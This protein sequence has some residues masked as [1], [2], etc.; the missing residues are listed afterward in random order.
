M[1]QRSDL[2][3]PPQTLASVIPGPEGSAE[4]VIGPAEARIRWR[5]LEM[6]PMA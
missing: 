5:R 6:T 4:P 1:L 2:N 3:V